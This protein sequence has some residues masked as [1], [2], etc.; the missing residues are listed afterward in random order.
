[1]PPALPLAEHILESM[2][3]VAIVTMTR[4]YV[5]TSWNEGAER[6]WGYT[7][8]EVLGTPVS[9]IIPAV[10]WD[11]FQRVGERVLRGEHVPSYESAYTR[12]DGAL[13]DV[14][15]DLFPIKDAVGTIVGLSIVARDVT[16]QNANLRTLRLL[17]SAVQQSQDAILITN[18][19]LDLPGPQI[20]FVNPAFCRMSG[21]ASEEILGKTPRLLQG[22]KTDRILIKALRASMARGEI[23]AG[24]TTNYRKDGTEYNVEWEIGPLYALNGAITHY[25]ATQR[26]VTERRRAQTRLQ[27]QFERL[28]ALRAIDMNIIHERNLRFTLGVVL[29]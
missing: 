10:R 12:K 25:V 14:E 13:I 26:D 9:R 11:E 16:L 28:A 8:S 5:I 21:Y 7:A 15:K 27:H 18:A 19:Q 4:Q 23:F 17:S 3:T 24:E 2:S 20:E 1:M 22:P 6:L 29:D